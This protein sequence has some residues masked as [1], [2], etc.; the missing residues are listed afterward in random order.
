MGRVN[1]ASMPSITRTCTPEARTCQLQAVYSFEEELSLSAQL[2]RAPK[3]RRKIAVALTGSSMRIL[4][5]PSPH[6]YKKAP[7]SVPWEDV[8]SELASS[9]PSLSSPLIIATN[10][11]AAAT[12]DLNDPNSV[13]LST[14]ATDEKPAEPAPRRTTPALRRLA[15]TTEPHHT[16]PLKPIEAHDPASN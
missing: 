7:S 10:F 6:E 5:G 16:P 12:D 1:D 14:Y 8:P 11:I 4:P 9:F 15:P 13:Q 3:Q 2:P